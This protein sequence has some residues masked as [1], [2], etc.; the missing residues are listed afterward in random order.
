[1][2]IQPK[3]TLEQKQK[4]VEIQEKIRTRCLEVVNSKDNVIARIGEDTPE[5]D[6][7]VRD[8]KIETFFDDENEIAY[9]ATNKLG[10]TT[11]RVFGR[12]GDIS[13]S[14]SCLFGGG[15]L[16][17]S[18]VDSEGEE[19]TLSINAG[20]TD[21]SISVKNTQGKRIDLNI[22]VDKGKIEIESVS[23]IESENK[24]IRPSQTLFKS[25]E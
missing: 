16:S 25:A 4:P 15:N 22:D 12:N 2:K 18:Y 14:G 10:I 5:T 3:L 6:E 21:A 13:I 17:V 23:E 24:E 11:F 9:L 7:E 8:N 1:M 19:T 20:W